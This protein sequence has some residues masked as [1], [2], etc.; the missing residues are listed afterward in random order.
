[1]AKRD[2]L[3]E[4]NEQGVPM[5][6]FGQIFCVRCRNPECMRAGYAGSLW[7]D[8]MGTQVERLLENPKY[9]DLSMPQYAKINAMDFPDAL[10]QA[11]KI[12]IARRRGDWEVPE[13]LT[14]EQAMAE[15]ATLTAKEPAKPATQA[16]SLAVTLVDEVGE[17]YT[18]EV[19]VPVSTAPTPA[20]VARPPVP[21]V[22]L[23]RPN[24]PFPVGG[25]VLPGA[26]ARTAPADPWAVPA[27]VENVVSIGAK[28]RL[29]LAAADAAEG[30]K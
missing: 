13:D 21:T 18:P 27:P 8:R 5:Q 22:P 2:W 6:E 19:P 10:R 12:E 4:C 17:P 30:K 11:L 25:V 24:T 7:A 28:I 20:P 26:G 16:A 14:E 29:G 1:M 9:A 3:Q 23:N 15:L